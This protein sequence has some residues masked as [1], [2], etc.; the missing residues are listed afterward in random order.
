MAK[1]PNNIKTK[2]FIYTLSDPDTNEIRYIGKTVKDGCENILK[3]YST[4]DNHFISNELFSKLSHKQLFELLEKYSYDN[5]L[6]VERNFKDLIRSR[7]RH[8]SHNFFLQKKINND[9]ID[10]EV[11]NYYTVEKLSEKIINLTV[12]NFEKF[13]SGD[14]KEIKKLSEFLEYDVEDIVLSN[15]DKKINANRKK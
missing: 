13:F 4:F 7:K 1:I 6:V 8:K 2:T 5:V 3:Y 11:I 14:K 9:N 12:I 15:L 10:E